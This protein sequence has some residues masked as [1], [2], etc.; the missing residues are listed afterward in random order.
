MPVVSEPVSPRP[1]PTGGQL[2]RRRA[3]VA[4][5]NYVGNDMPASDGEGFA[6]GGELEIMNLVGGEG[7]EPMP[8]RAIEGLRPYV[9]DTVFDGVVSDG[10][11]VRSDGNGPSHVRTGLHIFRG[12]F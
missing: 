7:R 9:T 5:E 3:S 10:L 12:R 2:L 1:R 4:Q 11:A 6:V 8:R